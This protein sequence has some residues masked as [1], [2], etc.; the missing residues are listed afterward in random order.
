MH[1]Y[2]FGNPPNI[3]KHNLA[4]NLNSLQNTAKYYYIELHL[5]S[6]PYIPISCSIITT[7]SYLVVC[8]IVVVIRG[9]LGWKL[10]DFKSWNRNITVGTGT[11]LTNEDNIKKI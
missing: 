10:I 11:V 2:L 3:L 1:K 9:M 7:L 8:I 5:V 6:I 4:V